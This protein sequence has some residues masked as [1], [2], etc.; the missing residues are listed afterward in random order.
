M[1]QSTRSYVGLHL[2]PSSIE[3]IAVGVTVGGTG[4]KDN[5]ASAVPVASKGDNVPATPTV[6][7]EGYVPGP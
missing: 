2:D 5:I 6:P 1:P 3:M 7:K 4:E